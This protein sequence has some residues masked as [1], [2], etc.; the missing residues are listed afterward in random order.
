MNHQ[1]FF[2]FTVLR[3]FRCIF[4]WNIQHVGDVFPIEKKEM[5]IVIP[6]YQRVAV[7][8][9]KQPRFATLFDMGASSMAVIPKGLETCHANKRKVHE[10][11]QRV[12]SYQT[13]PFPLTITARK[14][15]EYTV[16]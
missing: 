6:V 14:T 13:L 4:Y 9:Y 11:F 8:C 1:H 7:V 16:P 15:N 5:S 3:L 2:V 12:P 10:S